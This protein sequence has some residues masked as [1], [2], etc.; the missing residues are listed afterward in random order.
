MLSSSA[1]RARHTTC[2]T[3]LSGCL[4]STAPRIMFRG[5]NRPER[6]AN[7]AISGYVG[8]AISHGK[9][10]S[11]RLVPLRVMHGSFEANFRGVEFATPPDATERSSAIKAP[12]NP[13][14]RVPHA[15]ERRSCM[16]P[17]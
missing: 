12:H 17:G 9:E 16:D 13:R 4:L 11:R 6:L 10:K 3:M 15:S 14:L 8:I 2:I 1:W 7:T 5:R